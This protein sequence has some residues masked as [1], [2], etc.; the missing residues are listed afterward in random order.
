MQNILD[1]EFNLKDRIS[2]EQEL[3][4]HYKSC[5][6]TEAGKKV[7]EDLLSVSALNSPTGALNVEEANYLNGVKSIVLR[8]KNMVEA[9]L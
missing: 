5:F 2:K 8:I 9:K 7:L 4:K 3:I 1:E 6:N